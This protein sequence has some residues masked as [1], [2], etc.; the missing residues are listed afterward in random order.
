MAVETQVFG[1]GESKSDTVISC[2]SRG[3]LCGS[4][5]FCPCNCS[6]GLRWKLKDESK[7]GWLATPFVGRAHWLGTVHQSDWLS[8]FGWEVPNVRIFRPLLLEVSDWKSLAFFLLAGNGRAREES[9][10]GV[11]WAD[12]W[13][14]LCIL[15]AVHKVPLFLVAKPSSALQG[16]P[17][18]LASSCHLGLGGMEEGQGDLGILSVHWITFFNQC[19]F[20]FLPA[21]L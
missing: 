13:A 10:E 7:G 9:L 16:S 18:F 17:S 15:S 4:F 11:G 5:L 2:E 1:M 8:S 21:L 6:A 20:C 19:S 12:E 3:R 14:S